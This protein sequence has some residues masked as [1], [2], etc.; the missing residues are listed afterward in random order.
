MISTASDYTRMNEQNKGDGFRSACASDLCVS[1]GPISDA[2]LLGTDVWS[3]QN[4]AYRLEFSTYKRQLLT[5]ANHF[6][7]G[8]PT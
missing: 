1:F 7:N 5:C 3:S 6:V 2:G 8:D 4:L